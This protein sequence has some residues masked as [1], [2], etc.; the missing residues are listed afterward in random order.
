VDDKLGV[1]FDVMDGQFMMS[2]TGTKK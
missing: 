1:A 2:G